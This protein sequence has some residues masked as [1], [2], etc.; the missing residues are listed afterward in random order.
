MCGHPCSVP[1][2]CVSP[3]EV[4]WLRLLYMYDLQP[5]LIGRPEATSGKATG[6]AAR[7]LSGCRSSAPTDC[8]VGRGNQ[9]V[10]AAS[11]K[12]G[13][14]NKC[15]GGEGGLRGGGGGVRIVGSRRVKL[16]L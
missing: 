13:G 9:R 6:C 8:S 12:E 2:G 7:Q 3:P 5:V 16:A 1:V 14:E 15:G 11:W 4:I 10:R